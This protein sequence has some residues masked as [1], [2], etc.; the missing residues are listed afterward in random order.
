MKFIY[1]RDFSN[2]VFLVSLSKNSWSYICRFISMPSILSYWSMC[3]LLCQYD[4]VLIITELHYTLK[5]EIVMSPAL[6]FLLRRKTIISLFPKLITGLPKKSWMSVV[7]PR[8]PA[9]LV[10]ALDLLWR[11][12]NPWH[13][14]I[15]VNSI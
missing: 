3:L 5:S 9:L 14:Q 10:L 6:F 11:Q 7:V 8:K 4:T 12:A 15:L 1:W 2:W 13:K